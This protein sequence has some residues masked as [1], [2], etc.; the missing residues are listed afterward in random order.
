MNKSA[1]VAIRYGIALARNEAAQWYYNRTIYGG[2][3]ESMLVGEMNDSEERARQ[4]V[5]PRYRTIALEALKR[6]RIKSLS[7]AFEK[8][9][10]ML[11]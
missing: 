7:R 6:E 4:V 1:A 11:G 8:Y 2:M 9:Q 10:K 3:A 5:C